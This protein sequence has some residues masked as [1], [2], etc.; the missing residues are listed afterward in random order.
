MFSKTSLL[1]KP[2]LVDPHWIDLE[3]LKG[4]LTECS[5]NHQG[6]CN[7]SDPNVIEVD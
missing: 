7:G 2:R 5:L 1:S 6:V 4:W 3:L